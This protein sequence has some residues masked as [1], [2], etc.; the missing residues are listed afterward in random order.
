[1]PKEQISTR[2]I[3]IFYIVLAV[4]LA[5]GIFATVRN[6]YRIRSNLHQQR[7]NALKVPFPRN[8]AEK[9]IAE[10]LE[11][12]LDKMTAEQKQ[13]LKTRVDEEMRNYR[14]KNAEELEKLRKKKFLFLW[15][16]PAQ[17]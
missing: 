17:E 4:L 9:R 2:S 14:R 3:V 10:E 16:Y 8:E 11:L 12:S 6:S 13:L 7:I 1:M 5:A 15:S